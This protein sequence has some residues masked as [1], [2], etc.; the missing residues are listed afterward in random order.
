M[1]RDDTDHLKLEDTS[2]LKDSMKVG[3]VREFKVC[4]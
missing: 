2:G 1:L 3:L 4:A